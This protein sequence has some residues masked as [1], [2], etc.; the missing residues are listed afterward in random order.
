MRVIDW[1]RPCFDRMSQS[2]ST[3]N[4][5]NWR[6]P[7]CSSTTPIT[8]GSARSNSSISRSSGWRASIPWASSSP[9]GKSLRLDVT[10]ARARQRIAAASTCLSPG[11]GISRESMISSYPVTRHSAMAAHVS[12]LVRSRRSGSSLSTTTGNLGGVQ[13]GVNGV[14]SSGSEGCGPVQGQRVGW[15]RSVAQPMQSYPSE[16]VYALYMDSPYAWAENPAPVRWWA[17]A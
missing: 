9:S 7:A 12:R 3:L 8:D 6:A 13:P 15:C 2:L 10:M 1:T 4:A 11:S 5:G 14:D 17:P 16:Y